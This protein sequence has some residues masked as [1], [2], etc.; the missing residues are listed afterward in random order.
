MDGWMVELQRTNEKDR[1]I[2]G[3]G[4]VLPVSKERWWKAGEPIVV[5]RQGVEGV[6]VDQH[7]T[8][9]RPEDGNYWP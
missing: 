1:R 5:Q 9:Q 4:L 6:H 2:G 8:A 3:S 7:G